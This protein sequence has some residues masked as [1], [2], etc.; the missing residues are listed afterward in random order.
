MLGGLVILVYVIFYIVLVVIFELYGYSFL[1][2]EYK[3]GLLLYDVIRYYSWFFN[4]DIRV[5]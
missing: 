1:N 5:C 4:Y 2:C 3:V